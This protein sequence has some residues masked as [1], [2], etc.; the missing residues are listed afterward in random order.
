MS[1]HCGGHRAFA[2]SPPKPS[3]RRRPHCP[4]PTSSGSRPRV[5]LPVSI[6]ADA[7]FFSLTGGEVA[8]RTQTLPEAQAPPAHLGGCNWG[9][10]RGSF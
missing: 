6:W 10:G 9:A 8:M 7:D 2:L 4:R 3:A 5:S 1:A